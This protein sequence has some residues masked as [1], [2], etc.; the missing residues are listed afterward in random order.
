M[1]MPIHNMDGAL[2]PVLKWAGGK[3][4]LL[5]ELVKR[6][7]E[8]YTAYCEP[9][10]GGG[11]LAFSVKPWNAIL[12][13][14]NEGLMNL[15]RVI[16]DEP[17]ALIT[18]LKACRNEADFYYAMRG[19]DRIDGVFN[20]LGSVQKAVRFLYLNRTCFNGLYR[21][22]REGHFNTPFGKY[23]SPCI[24]DEDAIRAMSAYLN[25]SCVTLF[26]VD[27]AEGLSQVPEGGFVY[28][29]PPY[30]MEEGTESFTAYSSSGFGRS[31][32]ER[33]K[34]CCDF[35]DMKGIRFML[36]NA[37]TAFMRGL[38]GRYN[39]E[40]VQARRSISADGKRQPAAELIIRN[41][42]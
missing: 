38:Y 16:R 13:D 35:L 18:G 15:Y 21:V 3:R 30:D 24:C 7:P 27:F 4:A 10:L 39:V 2:K 1:G 22:N 17:E 29:D 42:G 8:T 36:S 19:L 34:V 23:K 11:A 5:P 40:A 41:Y 37:D 9:F 14:S 32:Q 25:K 33:L 26:G 28:L 31:E 20:M 6:M 12:G